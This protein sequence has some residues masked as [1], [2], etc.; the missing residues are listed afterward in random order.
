[1]IG[2]VAMRQAISQRGNA[3]LISLVVMASAMV[4][5]LG[6]AAVVT[7]EIQN[8]A[9]I[10]NAERA[11]YKSESYVEQALWQRNKGPLGANYN[12]D[13][14]QLTQIQAVPYVCGAGDLKCFADGKTPTEFLK[15]FLASATPQT[16]NNTYTIKRDQTTQFDIESAGNPTATVTLGSLAAS[17]TCAAPGTARLEVSVVAYSR[18]G[19]FAP[20]NTGTETAKGLASGSP[21]FIDKKYFSIGQTPSIT[22]G[23]GAPLAATGEQYPPVNTSQYRLRLKTFG[24][25]MT[26]QPSVRDSGNLPLR[27]Q[28]ANFVAQAVSQDGQSQRGIQIVTPAT[29]QAASIFD[30][31]LFADLNLEKLKG[32]QPADTTNP[33]IAVRTY[34]DANGNC[35]YDAG[36]TFAGGISVTLDQA[37]TKTTSST[38][39]IASF[40]AVPDTNYTSLTINTNGNA[41]ACNPVP[42]APYTANAANGYYQLVNIG[43]RQQS[44]KA[45]VF[46]DNNRNC[47]YDAGDTGYGGNTVYLNGGTPQGTDGSG[48]TT[49][50][51]LATG[52]Y[53]V[54]ATNPGGSQ[55]NPWQPC[56]G[57]QGVNLGPGNN[58]TVTFGMRPPYRTGCLY[59]YFNDRFTPNGVYDHF[60]ST[61]YYGGYLP[62]VPGLNGWY[63]EDCAFVVYLEQAPN[64]VPLYRYWNPTAADHFYTTTFYGAAIFGGGIGNWGYE[65]FEGYVYPPWIGQPVNTVPI[66]RY[67]SGCVVCPNRP[68]WITDHFYSRTG[69][70]GPHFGAYHLPNVGP[71]PGNYVY[72][73]IE[74]YA[75]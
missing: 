13:A 43:I 57:A 45:F 21:V 20:L 71:V 39:G 47:A 31:V 48:N 18:T 44:I 64:T 2:L 5:S 59:Q 23:S 60:Y 62:Y 55:P 17:G 53:S 74:G 49:Y 37:G 67:W 56:S 70:L 41:T 22:I 11:Y 12:I 61:T 16:A 40:N 33:Q 10:P 54:S 3:V 66:Y 51:N 46:V 69:N 24:C 50:A 58:V 26:I 65:G 32:K 52:S 8:V 73:G 42:A 27:I 35:Q 6:M 4:T 34:N 68:D 25:D 19:N 28:S 7:G 75:F 14:D 29:N 30:Y 72:E 63:L 1:M 36:E 15:A 38:D 9:S